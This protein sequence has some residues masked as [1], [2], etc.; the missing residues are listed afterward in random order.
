MSLDTLLENC[1][2]RSIKTGHSFLQ[3][4]RGLVVDMRLVNACILQLILSRRD[5]LPSPVE[6]GTICKYFPWPIDAK[7]QISDRSLTVNLTIHPKYIEPL[8][9]TLP[10]DQPGRIS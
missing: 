5:Q 2:I 1:V 6:W 4:G 8:Q 9:L 3:L 7:P 10:L